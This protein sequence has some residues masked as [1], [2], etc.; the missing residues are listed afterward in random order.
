MAEGERVPLSVLQLGEQH[1]EAEE[2]G[3]LVE[4]REQQRDARVQTEQVH[5]GYGRDGADAE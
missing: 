5:G 1:E 2:E 4:E 3:E